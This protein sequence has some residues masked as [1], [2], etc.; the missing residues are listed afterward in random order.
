[1]RSLVALGAVLLSQAFV[2]CDRQRSPAPAAKPALPPPGARGAGGPGAFGIASSGE[3]FGDHARL[4]PLLHEAGITMVRSFPEWAGLQ[5]EPGK[6]DWACG[7]ALIA[8]ARRNQ[9][10]IAG[11]L[12]Y[13]APWASSA[14]P[15]ADHGN[16]TRTFPIK[17]MRTWRDFVAGVVARYHA[18]VKWW[19]VY[20]EFNSP[21]FARNA[22][23]KDYVGMVRQAHEAAREV[24]PECKIGIGC[25]DA[26]LSFLEQVFVQGAAGCVDF[27][28]VHPYS[29]MGAVM[30]GREA[31]FLRLAANLRK[32]LARCGQSPELPLWVS[33]IGVPSTD[34]PGPEKKQAEAIAKAYVLCLAQ[35]IARVF[36]FEGRGPAYGPSGDFGILRSNWTPRPSYR[37][38]GTLTRLLGPRPECLGW[39]DPTGR[40]YAFVFQGAA[41]P[42]LVAW[43]ASPEGDTV[44]L[45]AGV[46]VVDLAGTPA[47]TQAERDLALTTVP[48]FVTGLPEKWVADART[49]HGQP[50][51]WLKDYGRAESVSCRMGVANVDGGLTQI[52][53]GDGRTVLGLVDGEH[54]RR[55][56]IANKCPYVYF[57]VDDTYASVG[58]AELEITL[59]ARR[60]DP[61]KAGGCKLCYESTK[62]YR[63]TAEWWTVPAG[64][65]WQQHTFRVRDANFANNWGWN[66]RTDSVGAPGDIWVKEVV[67]KRIG[68]GR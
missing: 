16:R 14:A 52:D 11:V 1:M 53:R 8:S 42:V 9:I 4:F 22:T 24:D 17:D 31:V 28:N 2:A 37:A 21:A 64:P 48:V 25:A 3:S 62:G 47:E 18:D 35:G 61:T 56:D 46:T 44:R 58:D 7:D 54:A 49:H 55:T 39:L 15:G 68:A 33:E 20:N 50:F 66:F 65:G 41:G 19:E 30:E 38:L 43:A 10:Q 32:M 40:S 67:V 12:C 26:D 57:D 59:V 5:P 29:L 60:V 13:L 23:V 45:P 6:W 36:W 27:V 51:P 63:A 34:A